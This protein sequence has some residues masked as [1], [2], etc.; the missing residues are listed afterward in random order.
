MSINV[1][2]EIIDVRVG[3]LPTFHTEMFIF[4]LT[5]FFLLASRVISASLC[6]ECLCQTK[7][8]IEQDPSGSRFEICITRA[9]RK[10]C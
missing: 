8:N 1:G 4:T 7:K 5:L 3:A 6:H 2:Y 9:P 10:N